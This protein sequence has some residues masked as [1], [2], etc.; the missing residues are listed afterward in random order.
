MTLL[1][2]TRFYIVILLIFTGSLT[3]MS[4]GDYS[5]SLTPSNASINVGD[6]ITFTLKLLPDDKIIENPVWISSDMSVASI[7]NRGQA[8]GIKAGISTITAIALGMTT[9]A[10]LSV[11]DKNTPTDS[12]IAVIV[13]PKSYQSFPGTTFSLIATIIP[14]S[15]QKREIIW[16]SSDK[17]V[18][19]V[20]KTGKV[21]ALSPGNSVISAK[22]GD[23]VGNCNLTVLKINVEHIEVIPSYTELNIGDKTKLECRILPSNASDRSIKWKS[24]D[25]TVA[26]VDNDGTVTGIG[27]GTTTVKATCD[28]KSAYATIKVNTVEV[29]G[30]KFDN[31]SAISPSDFTFKLSATVIP[32][33]ATDKTI[34]WKNS[35]DSVATVTQSGEITTKK[36]GETIITAFAGSYSDSMTLKVTDRQPDSLMLDTRILTLDPEVSKTLIATVYPIEMNWVKSWSVNDKSIID[37]DSQGKVSALKAGKATVTVRTGNQSASCLII[38]NPIEVSMVSINHDSISVN[39]GE[40]KQL[41]ATVY[42]SNASDKTIKW[43]SLDSGI[44]KVSKNGTVAGVS[45][46]KTFIIATSGTKSAICEV[47]VTSGEPLPEIKSFC[48]EKNYYK[49]SCGESFTPTLILDPPDASTFLL[50]WSIDNTD[51]ASVDSFGEVTGINPGH[52]VLRVENT[53]TSASCIIFVDQNQSGID[54]TKT[55]PF[56]IIPGNKEITISGVSPGDRIILITLGGKYLADKI[57]DHATMTLP[58]NSDGIYIVGVNNH[59]LKIKTGF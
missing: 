24:H 48:F 16:E 39:I 10:T 1:R 9:S 11:T 57:A 2:Q 53:S 35:N 56:T 7:D 41:E 17:T 44:A 59:F 27:S 4:N 40:K 30:I 55:L 31:V 32:L 46:G 21:T 5:L 34:I 19:T 23:K 22:C 13:T 52:T 15:Q 28:G 58:I 3:A 8:K 37:V 14:E 25:K 50:R 18:S 6:N 49:I 38:V 45:E 12:V 51:I 26:T 42:P 20:D 47:T 29:S 33:N 43:E 54:M 36:A